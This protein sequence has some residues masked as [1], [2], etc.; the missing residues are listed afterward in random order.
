[1]RKC[2]SRSIA[3]VTAFLGGM[4]IVSHAG[5]KEV[6]V[7]P[8]V[9]Q[10]GLEVGTVY[11]QPIEMDP[12]DM[13]RAAAESDVHLEA[14]VKAIAGNKNGFPDGEWIPA[15]D[16]H[17]ELVKIDSNQTVAGEMMPMVAND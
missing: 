11:L 3:S 16:L 15:L 10:N 2:P 9:T 14:D 5:A 4:L 6:P 1:M 13:M 8:H 17:Y 12:P 7:G